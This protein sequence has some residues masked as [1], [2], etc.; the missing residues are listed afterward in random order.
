[1][2]S[3]RDRAAP[4]P[5][6]RHLLRSSRLADA[7]V[8]DAGVER[9]DLVV[10]V[11]AG[12]GMLTRALLRAGAR[13]RAVEPDA[14]LA[15]RLRRACPDAVVVAADALEAPWPEEVFRVVA[16]VPFAHT[17]DICRA[18]L[19]DPL[20]PLLSADL[21][22]QWD[23][24][25]KRARLWPSTFLGVL[26]STW[27]E[28]SV[29]RR[30][31]PVAFAP[32]PPVAAAVLRARRRPES[33]V[34]APQARAYESF[35]RRAYRSGSLPPVA[36]LLAPGLGIDPRAGPRDLDARAWASLWQETSASPRSV[37]SMTRRRRTR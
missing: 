14:R 30:I 2:S 19:S 7:I 35:V 22:V 18:L 32:A 17:T 27:Y 33:L 31:A 10:D 34:P 21:I 20:V 9:R 15:A 12:S 29:L 3:V 13:V 1:M 4:R 6:G 25:L 16:N 28:L 11:G 26:W 8:R 36:R 37:T 23:A 24:A 5:R